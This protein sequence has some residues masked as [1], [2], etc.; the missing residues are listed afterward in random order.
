ME[1]SYKFRIYPN[2]EQENL[3]HRTFGCCRYV[4][5]HYLSKRMELYKE[6]GSTMNYVACAKDLTQLKRELPWLAEVDATALQSSLRNLDNAFQ[7]FF[8]R[9]KNKERPYGYPKFKSKHVHRKSYVSKNNHGTIA[10]SDKKIRLP[11]LGMVKCRIS[12]EVQGRILSATVSQ[13]PSGKYFVSLCCT[14]VEIEKLPA[15]G[16]VTGVDLGVKALATTAEGDI[17][18]N[19]KYLNQSDKKL[20][21]LARRLSRKKKGSRNYEKARIRKARLEEHIANQRRDDIQKATTDLIRKYDVI[22]LEDL[23]TKGMMNDHRLARSIGDA[24]FFEFR[25]ELEYKAEFYGREVTVIDAFYPSSHMCSHCGY[26]NP[27]TRDLKV[28]LWTCPDC[29]TN[30]DRDINA[31][32]NIRNEGLRLRK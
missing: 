31:A 7:N 22:C 29:G 28:R 32:I 4:Y 18:P 6:N 23:K 30:H 16:K 12:K 9:V 26:R 11:K 5:N 17:Y 2:A 13:N 3:I 10:L 24:S 1:Y 21:R 8:R 27:D 25:R 14:E 15:A 20:R 19:N